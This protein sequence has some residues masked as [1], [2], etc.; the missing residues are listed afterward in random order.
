MNIAL[1]IIS[2]LTLIILSVFLYLYW[3]NEKKNKVERASN[4]NELK[5]ALTALQTKTQDA[6]TL[7]NE[8]F[9]GLAREVKLAQDQANSKINS[10]FEQLQSENLNI[11]K[12]V[13][14][15][16]SEIKTTFKDYSQKVQ[17]AL[18][19]YSEDNHQSKLEANKLKEKMYSE[20]QN[21]LKEIKAPLDLD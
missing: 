8:K 11:Q 10:G 13:K 17:E 19:K 15:N 21:I 12:D 4:I 16:I 14:E 6:A 2:S 7:Q 9:E 5:Q 3:T 1:I 18:I 20:L